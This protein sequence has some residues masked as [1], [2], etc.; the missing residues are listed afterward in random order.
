MPELDRLSESVRL[1]YYDQRGRGRS[2][3]GEGPD[4][5]TLIGEIE[6][7]D[8]IREW[9]GL[10]AVAVLGHSWGGVLAME[11]AIRHPERVTHLILM[12]TA[13]GVERRHP[14]GPPPPYESGGLPSSPTG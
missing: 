8:R 1:I 5:V 10:D 7:L 11:Y 13:P 4:D 3:S 9:T 12:N 6:D 2:F 14:R